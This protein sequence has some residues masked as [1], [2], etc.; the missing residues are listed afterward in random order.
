MSHR[1]VWRTTVPA[2]EGRFR[3]ITLDLAG[4]GDSDKPPLADYSIP[5][6]ARR[7]LALADSLGLD[8]FRLVGHS[9][10]GQIALYIASTLAPQRIERLVSIGG[11]VTGRLSWRVD[12]VNQNLVSLGRRWP[13]VYR[14]MGK[15]LEYPFLARPG[16]RPWFHRM[17]S[18]PFAGWK[19]D[20]DLGIRP[21]IAVSAY[22]AGRG[23]H[24]LDLTPALRAIACPTLLLHGRQDGTV[25][26]EQAILAGKLIPGARLALLEECGHFPMYEQKARYLEILQGFLDK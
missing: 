15:L 18:L 1:G 12:H 13:G 5:A 22:E 19:I 23:L 14:L 21:E 16:F 4:F 26:V 25:P 20:R 3:C 11:V 9:M 6:Q 24:R 8:R 10:G 2:L 7:I 17:D